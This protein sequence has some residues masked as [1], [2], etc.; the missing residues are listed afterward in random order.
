MLISVLI[1]SRARPERLQKTLESLWATVDDPSRVEVLV[2]FD[3][4]DVAASPA[5]MT[6]LLHLPYKVMWGHRMRGYASLNLMYTELAEVAQGKYVMIMNDDCTFETKG[7]DT[8]LA[9]I[10]DGNNIIQFDTL[11][12]G[13]YEG[14]PFPIVHNQE[15][16]KFGMPAIADPADT[17]LDYLLRKQNGYTT[18]WLMGYYLKHD[19][20]NDE[21]LAEHRKL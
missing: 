5:N 15:W 4:D 7:W 6:N 8:A 10:E 20:D 11:E 1:P 21:L 16:K 17:Q 2:R 18:R 13:C 9:A 12:Y 3:L 19:R 14:G